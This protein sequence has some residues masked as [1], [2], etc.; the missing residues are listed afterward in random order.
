[1]VTKGTV[2]NMLKVFHD[3]VTNFMESFTADSFVARTTPTAFSIATSAWQENSSETSEFVYYADIVVSGL[4]AN[5]YAEVNFNRASQRI[6]AEANI[7]TTGETMAG[8]IR[9]YAEN[10]PTAT[11]GGEYIIMKGAA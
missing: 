5:D 8:K 9:I 4:T 11:I 6:V 2:L 1:M 3:D 10:V 7:C